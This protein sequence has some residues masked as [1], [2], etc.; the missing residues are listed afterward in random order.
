MAAGI[1]GIFR[2]PLFNPDQG[3]NKLLRLVQRGQYLIWGMSRAND[4]MG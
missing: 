4:M 3:K 2:L 1:G